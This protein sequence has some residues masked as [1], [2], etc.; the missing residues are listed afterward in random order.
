M[1]LSAFLVGIAVSVVVAIATR[2]PEISGLRVTASAEAVIA[3]INLQL[4]AL[5]VGRYREERNTRE[6]LIVIGLTILAL[7][8]LTL[9]ILPEVVAEPREVAAV[10]WI[11]LAIGLVG[12]ALLAVAG[13]GRRGLSRT[14]ALG[15]T[16]LLGIS[17]VVEVIVD[18]PANSGTGQSL[19]AGFGVVTGQLV[20]AT[21]FAGA[22]LGFTRASAQVSDRTFAWLATGFALLAVASVDY[23]VFRNRPS[24]VSFPDMMRASAYAMLAVAIAV[25]VGRYW[26]RLALAHAREERRRIARDLHDGLAQELAFLV[27]ETTE[28][29]VETQETRLATVAR[30]AQRALDESRRAIYALSTDRPADLDIE[31]RA[32][33]EELS[34]RLGHNVHLDLEEGIVVRPAQCEALV[35]IAREAVVN[36]IRH[37][38][39]TEVAV[40]LHTDGPRVFLAIADGGVGIDFDAIDRSTQ[41]GLRS[42]QERCDSL[43]ARYHVHSAPGNGTRIEVSWPRT[44]LTDDRASR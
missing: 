34:N 36:S 27:R 9:L 31:L 23:A 18:L 28:L 40:A 43:G 5:F 7:R 38:R 32:A 16:T 39:T 3:L 8:N 6:L 15:L 41:F 12:A 35:R 22:A 24:S 2:H 26:R 33:L 17:I 37:S 20:L 44:S 19:P 4:I 25:E 11:P 1:V 29:A 13:I 14:V 10:S 21:L 30:S 42:M